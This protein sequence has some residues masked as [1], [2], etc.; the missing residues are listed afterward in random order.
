VHSLFH[1]IRPSISIVIRTA[2]PSA[3]T[4]YTYHRPYLAVDP[5]YR[6]AELIKKV[7]GVGLLLA[8]KDPDADS[9]IGDVV[10]AVDFHTAYFVLAE[11][12]L[13]LRPGSKLDALFDRAKGRE[14]FHALIERARSAHGALVDVVLPVLEEQDRQRTIIERRGAVSGE[15]H[16]FLLALLL[17]V[18]EKEHVLRLVQRRVPDRDPV[19]VVVEWVDQL[20]HVK[21]FGSDEPNILG[22]DGFGPNHLK[23]LDD[24]LRDREAVDA[25]CLRQLDASILGLLTRGSSRQEERA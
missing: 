20:A 18:H 12:H 13:R 11:A 16:R 1:L 7:S 9:V 17:N 19:D 2:T 22:V 5:S 14:R 21:V 3:A 4:Q 8:T 24:A 10:C 15:A 25:Q 23:A 6:N